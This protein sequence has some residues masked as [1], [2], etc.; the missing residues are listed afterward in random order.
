MLALGPDFAAGRLLDERARL[1][2]LAPTLARL[3]GFEFKCR[4]RVL[5]E[6]FA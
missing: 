3:L 6:A 2:D 4:G 1:I 5:Q